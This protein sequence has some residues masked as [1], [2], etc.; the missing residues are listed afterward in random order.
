MRGLYSTKDTF[1]SAALQAG[2]KIVRLENQTGVNYVAL[3]RHYGKWMPTEGASE[4][5]RFRALDPT[6]FGGGQGRKIAPPT[7]SREEQFSERR[8]VRSAKGGT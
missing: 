4:L 8:S 7:R 1:V 3:R 5:A 2:V 6:L